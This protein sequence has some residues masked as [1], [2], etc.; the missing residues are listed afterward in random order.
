MNTE[1][2]E[3]HHSRKPVEASLSAESCEREFLAPETDS[4]SLSETHRIDIPAALNS[5]TQK[6][7]LCF[8]KKGIHSSFLVK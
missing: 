5:A 4:I 1:L 7:K 2:H 8:V 3:M 6:G